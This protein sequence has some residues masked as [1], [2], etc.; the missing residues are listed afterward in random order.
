VNGWLALERLRRNPGGSRKDAPAPAT[1]IATRNSLLTHQAEL[2]SDVGLNVVLRLAAV[3]LNDQFLAAEEIE[4]RFG[5]GAIVLQAL[6]QPVFVV[7]TADDQLSSADIAR[8]E[9]GRS[10]VDQV[11]VETALAT[12]PAREDSFKDDFVRNVNVDH[13]VD[14][15]AFEEELG[16]SPIARKA[17]E[18]EA[19]VPIVECQPVA[20][21]L[22]DILIVHHAAVGD[23]SLDSRAEFCVRLNVPAK[24]VSNG[25]VDE[26]KVLLESLRLRSFAAAL[27]A[28]DDVLVHVAF[29]VIEP[30][31][32]AS[33]TDRRQ[34]QVMLSLAAGL[35]RSRGNRMALGGSD[36]SDELPSSKTACSSGTPASRTGRP[37]R[38]PLDSVVA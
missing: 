16:L 36:F 2:S 17:V 25:D 4:D 30:G 15:V 11:V 3:G 33:R 22:F 31:P 32:Q 1:H 7:V 6:S 29:R 35:P 34:S 20:D 5:L 8:V 28:H 24:D 19:E 26:I 23:E 38:P 18:D 12:E 9:I 27:R 14:V 10:V 21:N 13:G 37:E